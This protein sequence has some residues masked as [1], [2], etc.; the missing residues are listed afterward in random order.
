MGGEACI[1]VFVVNKC[2]VFLP[3]GVFFAIG[4]CFTRKCPVMIYSARGSRK[5][6]TRAG[7]TVY[8]RTSS[9]S[10]AD[11]VVENPGVVTLRQY[12]VPLR[13]SGKL[14]V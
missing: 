10:S 6:K 2:F 5:G 8:V 1:F 3:G 9:I 7:K 11:G 13:G 12:D 14:V 4:R